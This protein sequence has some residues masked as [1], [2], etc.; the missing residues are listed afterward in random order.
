[1]SASPDDSPERILITGAAGRIGRRMRARLARPGRVLRLFDVAELAAADGGERV[2]IVRGSVTDMDAVE[3]ACHD[4]DAVVHLAGYS[5]EA[6]WQNI[7]DVNIGGTYSV[8]EAARRR[9]VPRVIFASSAHATGYVPFPPEGE[10]PDLLYPR[11]D[12]NYGVGKVVGE[13]IGSLYADRYGMDVICIRIGA[14]FGG[15]GPRSITRW[16]SPDD[17]ARLLDACLTVANPGF[18]LVWGVSAN[19]RGQ[20]SLAEARRLG[21]EPQDDSETHLGQILAERGDIPPED[22]ALHYVGG[23]WFGPQRSGPHAT[24]RPARGPRM[25]GNK[26]A[27]YSAEML[28]LH[29]TND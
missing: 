26:I 20:F 10:A 17:C 8:F 14:C 11:P 6:P 13:A 3:K 27:G 15:P 29:K 4:V 23:D 16:L 25:N 22:P 19:T 2:E 1:M 28:D 24:T 18:R 21:Y 12:T 9:G 7:L 5:G